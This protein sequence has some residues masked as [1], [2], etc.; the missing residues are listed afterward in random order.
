[1]ESSD[2]VHLNE[3]TANVLQSQA[4]VQST[5]SSTSSGSGKWNIRSNARIHSLN[6]KSVLWNIRVW[7]L[8]L[9]SNLARCHV[10]FF[11]VFEYPLCVWYLFLSF[12]S[13]VSCPSIYV[14]NRG[15]EI[16]LFDYFLFEFNR[17]SIF[18]LRNKQN[19]RNGRRENDLVWS[20]WDSK[21]HLDWEK[22]EDIL[23]ERF[24]LNEMSNRDDRK[25]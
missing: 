13:S 4:S 14:F 15:I 21:R 12:F 8:F 5:T 9:F 10:Y 16:C 25:F 7:F 18:F 24:D 23:G 20:S 6:R 3:T 11:F 22:K 17:I 2:N 1:M 19:M